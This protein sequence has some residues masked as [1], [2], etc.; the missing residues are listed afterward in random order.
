MGEENAKIRRLDERVHKEGLRIMRE[1]ESM[2]SQAT[3][4][5]IKRSSSEGESMG[6]KR[7]RVEESERQEDAE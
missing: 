6:G 7:P 3:T 4:S 5:G 2:G 1:K